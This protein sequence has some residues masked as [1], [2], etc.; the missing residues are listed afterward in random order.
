VWPIVASYA[1][2]GS[3]EFT[4]SKALLQKRCGLNKSNRAEGT[5]QILTGEPQ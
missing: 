2:P 4:F 5:H 3:V 1:E